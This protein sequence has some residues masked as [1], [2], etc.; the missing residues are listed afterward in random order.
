MSTLARQQNKQQTAQEIVYQNELIKRAYFDYLRDSEGYAENSIDTYE[1]S[2]LLWQEFIEGG[3]L[4][5]FNKTKAVDFK[6]WLSE[7]KRP[8]G[9]TLSLRYQYNI[10]RKLKDFF[11]WLAR[12]K[13]F[14]NK[15]QIIDTDYLSL[16]KKES[17]QARQVKRKKVPTLENVKKVIE[18]IGDKTEVDQRDRALLCLA[19]L[20]GARIASLVSS[21]IGS[22][23]RSECV[24]SQDPN[25]GVSTK[26]SKTITT[27]FFPLGYDKARKYFLEWFDYLVETK[28]YGPDDPIFP[29]T[30]VQN[31]KENISYQSTGEVER[32]RWKSPDSARRIFQKRF[33]EAGVDYHNPHSFRHLVVKE[34]IK[35]PL[36]EEAKKAISQNLG[37]EDV[38]TT[39]GC[40]GYG[41]IDSERQIDLV[42]SLGD[43]DNQKAENQEERMVRILRQALKAENK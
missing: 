28:G 29:I 2:V 6:R 10:L 33:K 20:T 13:K 15:I 39:F 37:H 42:K 25:L 43:I 9:K 22:F 26:F 23:D 12:Q 5:A 14:R 31:G 30:N 8:S 34:L 27:V 35:R 41:S 21:T 36:T 19:M 1:S 17:R 18:S 7:R 38:S 16:S 24:I 11:E 4:T 40:F 32:A 3:E